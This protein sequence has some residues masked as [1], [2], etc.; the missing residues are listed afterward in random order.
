MDKAENGGKPENSVA[1]NGKAAPTKDTVKKSGI[2]KTFLT[3][4]IAVVLITLAMGSVF[5]YMIHSNYYGLADRFRKNLEKVPVVK[6][7]LPPEYDLEVPE[8][9]PFDVLLEKYASYR[10]KCKEFEAKITELENTVK[11]LTVYK[12]NA[13]GI[14]ADADETRK[15]LAAQQAE[16]DMKMKEYQELKAKIDEI[17]A[18]KDTAEFKDFY[19]RLDS[20]NAAK[21]YEKVMERYVCSSEVKEFAKVYEGM[22][23]SKAATVLQKIGSSNMELVVDI[24]KNMSKESSAAVMEAMRDDFAA[25][26][27]QHLAQP[28]KSN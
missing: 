10:S 28:R 9:M 23:A 19:E 2:I 8:K 14:K 18:G 6:L 13:D 24:L 7:I 17:I 21:V 26:V 27:T 20:Q 16:L 22:D 5:G 11:E 3:L 4:V 12:D 25:R 15:Q 1:E